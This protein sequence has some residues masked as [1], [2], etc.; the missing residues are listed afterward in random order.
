MVQ[1]PRSSTGRDLNSTMVVRR[2]PRAEGEVTGGGQAARPER[3]GGD[4]RPASTFENGLRPSRTPDFTPAERPVAPL[5]GEA[6]PQ[7]VEGG[8]SSGGSREAGSTPTRENVPLTV[9]RGGSERRGEQPSMERQAQPQSE[10]RRVD[11]TESTPRQSSPGPRPERQTQ[12][13]T[14][15]SQ[16][17]PERSQP[18]ERSPQSAPRQ[19]SSDRP[20][21]SA[22][23]RSRES[24]PARDVS[25]KKP[26]GQ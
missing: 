25:P 10:P 22:P 9:P 3:G 20:A 23:E 4:G 2:P 17:T 18:S 6:R 13:S 26:S 5:P 16:P 8:S 19:P 11:R 24:A 1:V 14:E 7:R 12:P 15:R 21:Q